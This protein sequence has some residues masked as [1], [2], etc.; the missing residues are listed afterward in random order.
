MNIARMLIEYASCFL[1]VAF[2]VYFFSSFEIKRFNSRIILLI[3]SVISLVY[4]SVVVFSQIKNGEL[5][6]FSLIITWAV[7]F[8]YHFKWYTAICMSLI[9]SVISVLSE[10]LVMQGIAFIGDE[11]FY[12]LNANVYTYICGLLACKTITYI[13]ILIIRKQRHRSFQSVKGM[14]F[15]GLLMLPLSTAVLSMICSYMMFEYDMNNF[16]KISSIIA[17]IF[18][19]ISNIM[20]FY[21]VDKQYEIISAKEKLKTSE[22]LFINQKQYYDDVFKSQQ[23]VRKT[24]HD[25]KNLFIALLSELNNGNAFEAQHIIEN[26]L[27][28]MNQTVDISNDIDNMVDAVIYSKMED[29]KKSCIELNVKK[30]INRP[31]NIES[32]DLAV[33]VANILDNAIEATTAVSKKRKIDF[34]LFTENDSLIILSQNPT[35]NSFSGNKPKTTKKDKKHH[36]FGILSIESVTKKYN[37]DYI[38]ECEDGMATATVILTN[39]KRISI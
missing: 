7:S 22:I 14:R 2:C 32:L 23:E 15:V 36:G 12:T 10:M 29:A 19:L 39:D 17:L 8:C 26:K 18:L 5:I 35:V 6:F 24:R 34:S 27:N 3:L 31:V 28:E 33:L 11:N 37:G 4:G 21:I 30:N 16:L 38:L 25:L 1:E 20:I 9:F 13:I